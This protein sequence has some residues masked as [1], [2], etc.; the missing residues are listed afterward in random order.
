[1]KINPLH[2]SK[3]LNKMCPWCNIK[4]TKDSDGYY[5]KECNWSITDGGMKEI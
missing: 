4:L 2:R 5:C 1:M 3:I